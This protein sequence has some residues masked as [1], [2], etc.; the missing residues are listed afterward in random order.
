MVPP[1]KRRL[2]LSG[3]NNKRASTGHGNN[4]TNN[5]SSGEET[6][7][8]I[9]EYSDEEA[10][11]FKD[12]FTI[13]NIAD[14]FELCRAQCPLKY[15]SVLLYMSLKRF[16]ITWKDC[17]GFL[18]DIGSLKA[19]TA[20]K[21]SQIFVSGDFDEFQ[22]ENRGGKHNAE[23]YDYFPEIENDAK[24]FTLE[25]CSQKSADFTAVDLA[26]FIDAKYYEKTNLTKS[27]DDVLIRSVSSCRVD[28]RRWGARFK[29]NSQR[30]YFEGHER[31]D[32]IEHRKQF[33]DYFLDQKDSYYRVS[34]DDKPIWTV[35]TQNPPRVLLCKF[36]L[37]KR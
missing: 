29:D 26:N 11:S 2:H 12:K 1:T 36:F 21:W 9:D 16:G 23:F 4:Q 10:S 22:G 24:Q 5:N 18:R 31:Q 32:V 27:A 34:N 19:Q 35:P 13:G 8:E 7:M 15:L 20:H 14:L 33:I 30:P 6:D 25:R 28:L 17:D 37:G 3:V